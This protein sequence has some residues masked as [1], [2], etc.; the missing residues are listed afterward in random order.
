MVLWVVTMDGHAVDQHHMLK[1]DLVNMV[2]VMV[3]IA[4]L[5]NHLLEMVDIDVVLILVLEAVVTKQMEP[6]VQVIVI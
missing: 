3:A 6:R 2:D 5:H 1:E 4:N